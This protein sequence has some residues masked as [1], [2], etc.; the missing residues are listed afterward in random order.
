VAAAKEQ[1]TEW[2]HKL[3]FIQR[4]AIWCPT[5]FGAFCAALLVTLPVVWG[6]TCGES[7]LSLT[8][9]L[10]PEVLAVE[11]WIGY[12]GIRAAALEFKQYGYRYVVA[13]GGLTSE[14]WDRDRFTYAEMAERELVRS[15]VPAES[16]IV[17]PA[18]DSETQRTYESAVA[19]WGSLQARGIHPK[20]INVFTW[21]P[22]ARRS[23]LVFSKVARPDTEVGVI[24]WAP[25]GYESAPWWRSSE[26]SR[27]L[28]TE[29]AGFV[30]ELLLNSGRHASGPG[31]NAATH[32][33]AQ[34]SVSAV[35]VPAH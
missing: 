22:H 26:R 23:L 6:W 16:I 27:E 32:N 5:W 2:Y 4:R 17:A 15:G 14:R 24:G 25:P 8:H 28:L 35:S 9:R 1:R 21:A 19:A 7:F 20:T 18:N 10:P 34:E 29:S 31:K 30:F 11:G 12:D 3:R 13:T 33:L